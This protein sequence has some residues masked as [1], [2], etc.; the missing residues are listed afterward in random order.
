[1]VKNMLNHD[2]MDISQVKVL[3]VWF[4]RFIDRSWYENEYETHLV[5]SMGKYT[6][7]VILRR[8]CFVYICQSTV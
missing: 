3:K 8:A 1:M 6:L 7:E 2:S 5:R 4:I